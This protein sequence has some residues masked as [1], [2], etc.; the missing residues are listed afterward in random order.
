MNT[1]RI[2]RG[3]T[4]FTNDVFIKVKTYSQDENTE[5]KNSIPTAYF[6]D[7]GSLK[8]GSTV[9]YNPI[10]NKNLTNEKQINPSDKYSL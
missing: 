4:N 10:S 6:Y 2:I 8:V 1:A 9:L 5:I 7:T 3:G